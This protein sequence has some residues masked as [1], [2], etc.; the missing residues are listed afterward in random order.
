LKCD[1]SRSDFD[2][3]EISKFLRLK[4]FGKF[5]SQKFTE[6]C[7]HLTQKLIEKDFANVFT[8]DAHV[9]SHGCSIVFVVDKE[10]LFHTHTIEVV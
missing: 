3:L 7:Q 2:S 9:P 4:D 1:R 6:C 8:I 5:F 10:K